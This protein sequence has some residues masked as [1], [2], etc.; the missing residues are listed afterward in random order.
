MAIKMLISMKYKPLGNDTPASVADSM[1]KWIDE[2]FQNLDANDTPPV[3]DVIISGLS[4]D[5]RVDIEVYQQDDDKSISANGQALTVEKHFLND[6]PGLESVRSDEFTWVTVETAVIKIFLNA[7][8]IPNKIDK[9]K[10]YFREKTNE[11][12]SKVP[13]NQLSRFDAYCQAKLNSN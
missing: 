3:I 4:A 1:R 7:I 8:T 5:N 10:N 2:M 13:S 9:Q 12:R 6:Y 11:I